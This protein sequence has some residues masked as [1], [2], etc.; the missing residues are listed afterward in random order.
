MPTRFEN[1]CGSDI[2]PDLSEY[3]H[4]YVP[5][6]IHFDIKPL[7]VLLDEGIHYAHLSLEQ[8]QYIHDTRD[9]RGLPILPERII[10]SALRQQ[11]T[12]C[13]KVLSVKSSDTELGIQLTQANPLTPDAEAEKNQPRLG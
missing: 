9:Y 5:I 11:F 2:N 10:N 12:F 1:H 8:L 4:V 13:Q 7:L 3:M 6:Y